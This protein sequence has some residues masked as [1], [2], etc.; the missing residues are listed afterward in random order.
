MHLFL[1]GGGA[2][3]QTAEAYQRL[4]AAIDREKPLLYVPLA[5]ERER[6]QDCLGWIREELKEL[7][8]FSIEMVESGEDLAQKE[9]ERYCAVFIGGG[10]TF[11]LLS[12]LKTSGSFEQLKSYLESGGVV[13]GGSAGAIIFGNDLKACALDDENA[14]GLEDAAGFNML[15]GVS[16]LCHYTN[17]EPEKDRESKLYLLELSKYGRAAALPEED[18]L[19]LHDGYVEMIGDRP[20]YWFENG[21]VQEGRTEFFASRRS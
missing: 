2:G 14:V 5:M 17:R 4:G 8:L 16:L 1:C 9:L 11:K 18:T 20:W 7:R 6:C 12:D 21:E 10:N 3:R 15:N 19:Y 13:F